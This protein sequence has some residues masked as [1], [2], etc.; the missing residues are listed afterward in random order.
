MFE[1]FQT[2]TI[3]R[4]DPALN[5]GVV[6]GHPEMKEAASAEKSRKYP[7]KSARARLFRRQ[8]SR[9]SELRM[10]NV[11]IHSM[12]AE[13]PFHL[14]SAWPSI[15]RVNNEILIGS[16]LLYQVVRA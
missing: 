6:K 2:E 14:F 5:D 3:K 12:R 1:S 4:D 11:S 15:D 7:E 16:R 8:M 10:Q 9:V 13:F